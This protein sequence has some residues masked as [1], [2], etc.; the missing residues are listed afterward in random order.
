[1][2][3]KKKKGNTLNATEWILVAIKQKSIEAQ[4]QINRQ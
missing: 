3:Y 1:M 4:D 2:G